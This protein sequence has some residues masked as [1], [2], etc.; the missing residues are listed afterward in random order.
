[1]SHNARRD[2]TPEL[3]NQALQEVY[4]ILN[5]EIEKQQKKMTLCSGIRSF[6][7]ARSRIAKLQKQFPKVA[8]P[9]RRYTKPRTNTN[10]GFMKPMAISEE[11]SVFLSVPADTKLSRVEIQTA[12]SVYC[13]VKNTS[14]QNYIKWQHM[15][16]DGKRSLQ[17]PER[18]MHIIPDDVLSNLLRY[19]EYKKDVADGK[20]FVKKKILGGTEL[21]PVTDDRMQYSTIPRLISVHVK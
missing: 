9:T 1:M 20:I 15:N 8:K 19:D 4:D 16:P 10:N 14:S 6:K 5:I 7:S 12:I 18:K 11:L 2:V 17:N 21:V 13:N 3:F